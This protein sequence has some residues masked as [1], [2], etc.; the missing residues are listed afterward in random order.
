[1]CNCIQEINEQM[2]SRNTKIYQPFGFDAKH[3]FTVSQNVHIVTE[4][5][6]TKKRDGPLALTG[7][8]CPFCGMAYEDGKPAQAE[9]KNANTSA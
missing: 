5:I 8:Y 3:N 4:K 7:A 6:E 9:A 2:K 1:M